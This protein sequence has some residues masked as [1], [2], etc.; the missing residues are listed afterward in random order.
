M[1]KINRQYSGD[2][3]KHESLKIIIDALFQATNKYFYFQIGLY[4]IYFVP[5]FFQIFLFDNFGNTAAS[6]NG[7]IACNH[8]AYIVSIIFFLLDLMHIC[9][10]D[11]SERDR[12]FREKLAMF[13]FPLQTAYYIIRVGHPGVKAPIQIYQGTAPFVDD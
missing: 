4:A 7:V 11:S 10:V 9:L 2:I 3:E 5:M 8:I 6:R 13:W 12:G 1:K